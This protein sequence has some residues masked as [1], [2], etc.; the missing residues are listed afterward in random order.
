MSSDSLKNLLDMFPYFFDKNSTSNFFK[1]QSVTNNQF[2]NI[3]QSLFEL[4]ES[5][6]LNK[7]IL[8][9]REQNQD[10]V[11]V[12]NF[13]VNFPNLK[14][15]TLYKND[16]V[17]YNKSYL[18]EEHESSFEYSYSN[19][20]LNDVI[21][22]DIVNIIPT[23]NFKVIVETYD[24]YKFIKGYPENDTIQGNEYD[25][26]ES[27]DEIG[28]LHNIP[29]KEYLIVNSE[30]YPLTEPAYNNKLSEDDYHY[31]NRIIEYIARFHTYPLPVLELW[32]IYG[33]DCE[34]FNRER[35]LLKMFDETQHENDWVPEAWEHK[36]K[37]GDYNTESGV[38]LFVRANTL[39]PN[40]GNPVI[41]NFKF[42]N[43]LAEPLD[44]TYTVKIFF[45][46]EQINE[47]ENITSF[48]IDSSLLSVSDENIFR[49]VGFNPYGEEISSKEL[50]ILV[51]ECNTANYYV[52]PSEGSDDNNGKNIN[53][54]FATIRKAISN[55]Y[56]DKTLISLREGE[57]VLSE[58]IIADK[59]CT[60]LGCPRNNGRVIIR[61]NNV[62][63]FF[64]IS[65]GVEL[66]LK[67]LILVNNDKETV[68]DELVV[69]NINPNNQNITLINL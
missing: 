36:D 67:N 30:L 56:G 40:I 49:I 19:S 63:Q 69:R 4:L 59:S 17:I 45:N 64:K 37:F 42:L 52:N 34:M 44:G 20:T 31:M 14:N 21:E 61:N 43:G 54:A 53:E 23:D 8:I 25:H 5:F 41:F 12:I 46:D 58:P 32:K 3:Y 48:R 22:G 28:A 26:D 38:Y 29:R 24:E 33:I 16:E 1:S 9:W 60:L 27:L 11:Y 10:Y 47:I 13:V 62:N 18:L 55:V 66:T 39:N 2:K 7:R 68:I 35:Y 65:R 51:K 57:Y 50:I 15:I 6:K